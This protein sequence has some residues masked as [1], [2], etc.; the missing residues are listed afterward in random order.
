[1]DLT[2]QSGI[3]YKP[4]TYKIELISSS[5]KK[6]Y[7][8]TLAIADGYTFGTLITKPDA[9]I[10]KLGRDLTIGCCPA[11]NLP[12]SPSHDGG[13]DQKNSQ[14]AKQVECMFK[15]PPIITANSSGSLHW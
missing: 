6:L 8:V 13:N 11:K 4:M 15:L 10:T 2:Q 5:L 9:F 1:M 7:M 14:T 12:T 3:N